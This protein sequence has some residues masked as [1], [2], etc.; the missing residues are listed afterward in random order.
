MMRFTTKLDGKNV[1]LEG[2]KV[3]GF[4]AAVFEGDLRYIPMSKVSVLVEYNDF[5][6]FDPRNTCTETHLA[7]PRGKMISYNDPTDF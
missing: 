6:D 4:A 2:H 7:G 5:T 3:F 1:I